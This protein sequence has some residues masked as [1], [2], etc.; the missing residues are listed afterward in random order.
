M[1]RVSTQ[2]SDLILRVFTDTSKSK[3]ENDS[4]R[5]QLKIDLR[6][7][8][9]ISACLPTNKRKIKSRILSTVLSQVKK[10]HPLVKGFCENAMLRDVQLLLEERHG[11]SLLV[12]DPS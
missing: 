4:E 9:R 2:W 5:E 1:A 8:F 3:R 7:R 11:R 10:H 12:A 6:A